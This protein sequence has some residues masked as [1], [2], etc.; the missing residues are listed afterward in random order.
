MRAL[1]LLSQFRRAC[2]QLGRARSF[3]AG[4]RQRLQLLTNLA[5]IQVRPGQVGDQV[6]W[7][8]KFFDIASPG[9]STTYCSNL[10]ERSG[11]WTFP[12]WEASPL[13]SGC[14]CFI[15]CSRRR[16]RSSVE[17]SSNAKPD[18]R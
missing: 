11:L 4:R 3:F 17:V 7:W 5:G 16:C 12:L 1:E 8:L 14:S 6:G 9:M 18:G 10:F 2:C 13:H 15:S